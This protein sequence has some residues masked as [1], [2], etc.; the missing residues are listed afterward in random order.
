[1]F[2]LSVT[3]FP[4][5]SLKQFKW[6]FSEDMFELL[7]WTTAV[8]KKKSLTLYTL[9]CFLLRRVVVRNIWSR[10]KHE[11]V[12]HPAWI[13]VLIRQLFL[14]GTE[15][16]VW[17]VLAQECHFLL[18]VSSVVQFQKL[19]YDSIFDCLKY[20]VNVSHFSHL[21]W[22][23]RPA[24]YALLGCDWWRLTFVFAEYLSW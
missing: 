13:C 9:S 21:A 19:C 12:F 18:S 14:Q 5:S 10:S 6:P 16:L 23:L 4:A 15:N 11:S 24:D 2:T 3:L 22:T 7:L 17:I 20:L 8:C 1:M